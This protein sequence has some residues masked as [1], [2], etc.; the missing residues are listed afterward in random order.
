[1]NPFGTTARAIELEGDRLLVTARGMPVSVSL[2]DIDEAPA[3]R[4][5]A[6]GTTLSLKPSEQSN[7]VLR[8][9][10][11]AD[12]RAFADSVKAAWVSFNIAAF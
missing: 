6:F 5:G 10:G 11:P 4:K 2:A 9:A 3:L 1:M 8:G 7:V 12:A